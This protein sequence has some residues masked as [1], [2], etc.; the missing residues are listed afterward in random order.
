MSKHTPTPYQ[1]DGCADANGFI[2]IRRA[3]G[4]DNG[5]T[6]HQPI[7]TVFRSE[8]AEF[9]VRACNARLHQLVACQA[10]VVRLKA[11]NASRSR[12]QGDFMVSDIEESIALAEGR[13][14]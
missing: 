9:I 3:D 1:V 14:E 6:E 13:A 2:T 8:D 5:D 11:A 4:T 7:A 10:A 12:K